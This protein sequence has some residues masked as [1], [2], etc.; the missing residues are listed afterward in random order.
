MANRRPLVPPPTSPS[1]RT[2]G[3]R[4]HRV[5]RL[6][7]VVAVLALTVAGVV[8]PEV[9]P[10]ALAALAVATLLVSALLVRALRAASSRATA[11]TDRLAFLADASRVLGRSLDYE[12]TLETIAGLAVPAL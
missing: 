8:V 11:S 7:G 9:R 5:H 10:Y 2:S 12:T 1:E 3:S 4:S 6:A